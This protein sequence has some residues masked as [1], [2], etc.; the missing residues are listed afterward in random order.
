MFLEAIQSGGAFGRVG[1]RRRLFSG[2]AGG[3]DARE[4]DRP[5]SAPVS[6]VI[7]DDPRVQ[8]RDAIAGFASA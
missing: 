4:V 2:D 3:T 7:A 6:Q 8:E 5:V 1:L